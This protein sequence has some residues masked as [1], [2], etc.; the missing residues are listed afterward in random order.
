LETV[1]GLG[2]HIEVVAHRQ[3]VSQEAPQLRNI[4]R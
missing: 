3:H 2:D 1:L 4:I